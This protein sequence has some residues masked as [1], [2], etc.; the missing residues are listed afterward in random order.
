MLQDDRCIMFVIDKS[1]R[2]E[3]E[4]SRRTRYFVFYFDVSLCQTNDS[5]GIPPE[6]QTNKYV[7]DT[8]RRFSYQQS[9]DILEQEIQNF[10]WNIRVFELANTNISLV[11]SEI[12]C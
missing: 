3:A 4:R 6:I 8:M 10:T 2:S 9:L 7:F 1:G 11:L 12:I 5:L